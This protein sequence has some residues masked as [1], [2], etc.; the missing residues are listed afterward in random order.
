[1][2]SGWAHSTLSE[3]SSGQESDRGQPKSKKS[4]QVEL[5]YECYCITLYP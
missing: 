3:E 2:S 4:R 1:M 5:R